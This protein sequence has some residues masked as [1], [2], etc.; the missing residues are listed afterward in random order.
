MSKREAFLSLTLIVLGIIVGFGVGWGCCLTYAEP[1]EDFKL[2]ETRRYEK[3][4][5]EDVLPEAPVIPVLTDDEFNIICG[6]VMGEG[7][8]REMYIAITQCIKNAMD[9]YG[10]SAEETIDKLYG[11]PKKEWSPLVE[12][13]VKGVFYDG[14]KVTEEPILFYYAEDLVYSEWHETQTYVMT[15]KNTRFFKEA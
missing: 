4:I 7:N 5:V 3:V 13:V 10:W 15:I 1:P 2:I 8:G 9:I 12:E 14:L 6:M 11:I